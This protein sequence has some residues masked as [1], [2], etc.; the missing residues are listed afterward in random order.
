[1]KKNGWN[2]FTRLSSNFVLKLRLAYVHD[3]SEWKRN[4]LPIKEIVYV[5]KSYTRTFLYNIM[6]TSEVFFFLFWY[7][8]A[9]LL[10]FAMV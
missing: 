4:F 9:L 3:T 6:Y 2:K 1:M 10:V 5:I 8:F 7:M